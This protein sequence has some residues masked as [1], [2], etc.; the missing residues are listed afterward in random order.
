M[1]LEFSPPSGPEQISLPSV[2]EVDSDRVTM[3][4]FNPETRVRFEYS[5][6]RRF[7][8]S[9]EDAVPPAAK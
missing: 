9:T 5:N 1:S 4:G 6:V 2:Y 8:V 3:M 7:S